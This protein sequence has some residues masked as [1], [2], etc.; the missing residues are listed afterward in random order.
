MSES[1]QAAK[2]RRY[3]TA[4]Y[5]N[6]RWQA[7]RPRAGDL[8]VCAPQKCGTTWTQTILASLIFPDGRLPDA[9]MTLSPWLESEVFPEQMIAQRLEAQT[10]RRFIKSHTPADGIPFFPGAKYIVVGRDG[11]DAFMSLCNHSQKLRPSLRDA[12][13]ARADANG[14]PRQPA[15]TGDVHEYFRQW[16]ANADLLRHI[17]SFWH[18]RDD[19]RL[20]F[21]HFNDLKADLSCEMRRIAEFCELEVTDE[22]WPAVVHRCTFDAMSRRGDEIG[23]FERGYAG[24]WESFLFKGTNNRWRGVLDAEELACYASRVSQFLTPDAARWLEHGRHAQ[25]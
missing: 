10:H 17:S 25:S 7:F 1:S 20:L 9:V 12:M 5:D 11:R 4:S 19:P 23:E 8:F 21:V 14:L 18:R 3:R 16:L 2:L 24:G 6:A 15:W 13:N 22:L